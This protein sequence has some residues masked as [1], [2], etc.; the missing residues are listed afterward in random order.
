M[1]P[2][3][4]PAVTRWWSMNRRPVDRGDFPPLRLGS[5]I[6]YSLAGQLGYVLSQMVVL[7][8]LARMRGTE[9]VG[10]FGLALAVTTPA[11]IFITMGGKGSQASDVTQRYSFAE[12][13]GMIVVLAGLATFASIGAGALL[14]PT[15]NAF[16]IVVVIAF[17]KAAE[18]VSTLSYGAFQQAG[19]PDKMAVSLIVRGTL[20]AGLFVLLLWLGVATPL[21][22]LAQ[23]LVWTL[24]ACLRDY[25][26]ASCLADG[27]VVRPSSDRRRIWQL[28]RETAPLGF[29]HLVS[30]LLVS[31]PRLFVERSV[32]LSAV[33]LLTV[34]NYFQ[35]AATMLLTAT[36]QTLVNRLARLKQRNAGRK[37]RRTLWILFAFATAA[38]VIGVA[39]TYFAGEWVL[40]TV[41]GGEFASA[42]A[43]LMLVT[44][45][46]CA[47][48]YGTIPQSLMHA[49]RR[50]TTLLLRE[51][52]T[53]AVCVA[54]LAYCVPRWG[55]IGAGY[56][57]AATALIR[58]AILCL[59]TL[60]VRP[61]LARLEIAEDSELV[62]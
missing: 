54:L 16:L 18:S 5:A 46:V 61:G 3:A 21:A 55:L 27:R 59:A 38:S 58:L 13:A 35:Q 26:L 7:A 50:Y 1:S 4:S 62:P 52:V 24:L 49:E 14:A 48:L 34:V 36:G 2:G 33:G 43:L 44:I 19:R 23:L 8:A 37:L 31:L 11:F 10:E 32:G 22:F 30:S 17:T 29:S 6:G 28:A 12:Y 53:V 57:I 15:A 25:P 39:F 40:A 51:L 45:A 9:A 60:I 47:K 42:H 20:T 56:A 41:F